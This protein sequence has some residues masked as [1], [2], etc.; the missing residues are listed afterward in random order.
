MTLRL[1]IL[2]FLIFMVSCGKET[3]NSTQGGGK[4][5]IKLTS[6]PANNTEAIVV[7]NMFNMGTSVKYYVPKKNT[8]IVLTDTFN[9][10]SGQNFPIAIYGG[11]TTSCSNI[12]VEAYLNGN[13]YKTKIFNVGGNGIVGTGTS[14]ICD[15]PATVLTSGVSGIPYNITID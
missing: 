8:G 3:Q 1:Y 9:V 5:F 6:N 2:S 13:L 4:L 12:T 15:Y 10:T 14:D 7:G 11:V